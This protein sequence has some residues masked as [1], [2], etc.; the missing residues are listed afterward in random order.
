MAITISQVKGLLRARFPG[1]SIVQ[2]SRAHDGG[3]IGGTIAWAGFDHMEHARRQRL[4][5][6]VLR[7]AYPDA[8]AQDVGMI[9]TFTPDELRA[10][11]ED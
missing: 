9:L 6:Q 8:T 5:W 10:I 7:E 1:V 4:L 3:R 11:D 2:L